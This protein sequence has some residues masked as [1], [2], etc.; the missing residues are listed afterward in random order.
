[1]AAARSRGLRRPFHAETLRWSAAGGQEASQGR[2]ALGGDA[3][4]QFILGVVTAQEFQGQA[5]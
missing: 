1:M 2:G 3:V 5:N 4:Y